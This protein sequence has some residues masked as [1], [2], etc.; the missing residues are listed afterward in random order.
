MTADTWRMFRATATMSLPP[1]NPIGSKNMDGTIQFSIMRGVEI[2]D[3]TLHWWIKFFGLVE[4][5]EEERRIEKKL[6]EMV[7]KQLYNEI[8]KYFM[9]GKTP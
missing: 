5:H 4:S 8:G 7:D 3:G 9:T 1:R 6:A 2:D